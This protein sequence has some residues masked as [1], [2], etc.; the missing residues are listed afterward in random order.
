MNTNSVKAI[1]RHPFS[2][3]FFGSSEGPR[4]FDAKGWRCLRESIKSDLDFHHRRL[5]R[6]EGM[7]PRPILELKGIR[8]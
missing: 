8:Q 1:Y 3:A 7:L 5:Q 6:K 4:P 2:K